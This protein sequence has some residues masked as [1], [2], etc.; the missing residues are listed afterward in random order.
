MARLNAAWLNFAA[1][2]QT[3]WHF[4]QDAVVASGSSPQTLSASVNLATLTAGTAVLSAAIT[5]TAGSNTLILSAPT[6]TPLAQI[7]LSAGSNQVSLAAPAA[8]LGATVSL[9]AETNQVPFTAPNA[10]IS[11]GNL[12]TIRMY[13]RG[14]PS[15]PG[16]VM[17]SKQFYYIDHTS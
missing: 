10:S 8:T 1:R 17:L 9:F 14:R 15:S 11:A 2:G 7:T 6:A 5:L 12:A 4:W 3:W 13:Y 16:A